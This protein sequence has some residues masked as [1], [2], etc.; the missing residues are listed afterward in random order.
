MIGEHHVKDH[1]PPCVQ[2]RNGEGAR[3]L[4][5]VTGFVLTQEMVVLV[6][7]D[8]E[9][10][11]RSPTRAA[12]LKCT[13]IDAMRVVAH[14]TGNHVRT[15]FWIGVVEGG[16][17]ANGARLVERRVTVGVVAARSYLLRVYHIHRIAE[18]VVGESYGCVKIPE[19]RVIL[20]LGMAQGCRSR[21]EVLVGLAKGGCP[22]LQRIPAAL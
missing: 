12:Q 1:S 16:I 20:W 22:R 10:N 14:Q 4:R 6:F 13:R 3:F 11:L 19:I 9:G 2:I 17:A 21:A 5:E 18:A 7:I 15:G 8:D